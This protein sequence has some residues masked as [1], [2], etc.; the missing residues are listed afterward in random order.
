MIFINSFQCLVNLRHGYTKYISI[1]SVANCRRKV[2]YLQANTVNVIKTT[3]IY[4]CSERPPAY[5]NP[6]PAALRAQDYIVSIIE[7]VY[8]PPPSRELRPDTINPLHI[9]M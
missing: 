8:K 1:Y 6:Y 5:R 7:A 9:F 3:C 2:S 4:T